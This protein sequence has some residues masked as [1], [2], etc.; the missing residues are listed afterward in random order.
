MW[1]KNFKIKELL[2]LKCRD[3][4]NDR[5]EIT[6]GDRKITAIYFS[7]AAVKHIEETKRRLRSERVSK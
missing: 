4:G 7:E 6:C 3:L 2:P 1:F 5:V